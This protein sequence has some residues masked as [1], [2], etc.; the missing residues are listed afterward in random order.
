MDKTLFTK[1]NLTRELGN[2]LVIVL[3]NCILALGIMVFMRPMDFITGGATGLGLL[4]GHITGLPLSVGVGCLNVVTFLLG[5]LLLGKHFAATTLL[6]TFLYPAALAVLERIPQLSQLNSDPL[7]AAIFGGAFIGVGV[8]LVIRVGSSTGGMDIPP[9][10]ISKRTGI[11]AAHLIN[12]FDVLILC[13][14]MPYSEPQKVLYS[15][16]VVLVTTI[17]MDKVAMLGV[18]QTQVMV[19]SQKAEEINQAIQDRIDR[20]TTLFQTRSGYLKNAQQV[21]MSVIN[22]R[23]LHELTKLVQSIDPHAFMV[24]NRVHQ[25]Y[26][27][28]FTLKLDDIPLDK[29]AAKPGQGRA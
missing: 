22:N 17:T 25:V 29:P 18:T 5:L 15:F 20:G 12:G 21:V 1:E 10:I 24:V 16:L 14:Q 7:L 2:L 4:I 19:I 23:Q 11:P 26:G 27:N 6:S 28:G 13:T 8:G 9:I 3:G